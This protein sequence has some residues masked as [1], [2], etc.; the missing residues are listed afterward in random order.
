MKKAL[1]SISLIVLALFLSC[2]KVSEHVA[3][4][5]SNRVFI[6]SDATVLPVNFKINDKNSN[7]VCGDPVDEAFVDSDKTITVT[8][9]AEKVSAF[10][11]AAQSPLSVESV[12][13]DYIPTTASTPPLSSRVLQ[14]G[15]R[16]FTGGTSFNVPVLEANQK[17]GLAGYS[18]G[19]V[20]NYQV[21]ISVALNEI[22][23]NEELNV[24]SQMSVLM[25]GVCNAAT[26][27]VSKSGTGT[28]TVVSQ[29]LGI[30][31]GTTCSS[32]YNGGATVVLSAVSDPG[33]SFSGWVGGGCSGTGTCTIA[34]N[35]DKTV[36]AVFNKSVY[37]VNVVLS[38]GG[39]GT[40]T[41]A[42]GGINCGSTCASQFSIGSVTT[43][44]ASPDSAST[45][46]GWSG[47]NCSGTLVCVLP[48][49][50]DA[51]VSAT[52]SPK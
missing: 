33:S 16:V 30:S 21:K 43:L 6:S 25:S 38:G 41:S 19:S 35:G 2:G 13:I 31:C 36:N 47:G 15:G 48:G 45:F 1:P 42:P 29:P 17:V 32:I 20:Y 50:A 23:D 49:N 28:G 7:G 3:V 27:I 44:I 10:G 5:L 39:K 12:T 52:F 51:T 8:L 37:N 34:M 11:G 9:T 4:G 40:I 18:A 22:Y 24:S 46:T 26:L 14:F